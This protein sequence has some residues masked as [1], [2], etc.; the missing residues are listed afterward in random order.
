MSDF[1]IGNIDTDDFWQLNPQL[2]YVSPFD[3]VKDGKLMWCVYLWCDPDLN[4]KLY[5]LRTDVKLQAIQKYYPKFD[6]EDPD[7]VTIIEAYNQHRLSPAARALK[8]EEEA[9]NMRSEMIKLVRTELLERTRQNPF[10]MVDKDT[11][12]LWA[13]VEAMHSSTAKAYAQYEAARKLFEAESV[14]PKVYGGRKETIR[15]KG[16]LIVPKEDYE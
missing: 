13:K 5:R 4:N 15:E 11:Q 10:S 12:A 8:Q 2:K 16:N 9:L 7:Q 1:V 6:P 14:S 3:K